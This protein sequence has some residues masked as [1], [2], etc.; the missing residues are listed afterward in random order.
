MSL[1]FDRGDGSGVQTQ[2]FAGGPSSY[3]YLFSSTNTEQWSETAHTVT[4]RSNGLPLS[5]IYTFTVT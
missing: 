5:P 4:V 3:S 1:Q 2:T